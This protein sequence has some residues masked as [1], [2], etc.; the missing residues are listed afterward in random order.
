MTVGYLFLFVSLIGFGMLGIFHKV[1]DHPECRPRIIAAVL[2]FWGAVFTALWTALVEPKGLTFPPQVL[3]IGGV[4]GTF[5]GSAIFAFQSGLRFGKISTSW[6]VINLSMSIP[7]LFSIF[8]FHEKMNW[9]KDTGIILV[10]TAITLMWWDKKLDLDKVNRGV[11]IKSKWLPLMMFA[12][13][14]NGLA[15][16]SQKI[17]VE[18][19]FGDYVWQFY[20]ILYSSGFLLLLLLS[21]VR[22]P[23]PNRREMGAAFVMGASSV[24]GNVALTLALAR[25]VPG[26]IAFPIGNGG[27]LTL[28][29]LAGVLFFKE[30]VNPVG[31]FGIACGIFAIL[32]LVMEPTILSYWHA[33][34]GIG[35]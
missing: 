13:F 11:F 30:H 12:F 21:L 4:G 22:E 29:V 2:F 19:G 18:C 17:L 15:A 6:L 33:Y 31:R 7:I 34:S 27:S 8:L 14:A 23:M 26:S 1:A 28:V 20:I 16:A 10:L 25:A 24:T 35:K 3:I 32:L 9:I 5:S